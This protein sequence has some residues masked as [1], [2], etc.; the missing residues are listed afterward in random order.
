MANFK[1]NSVTVA[2]ESGGTVS[3]D[4]GVNLT[5][6]A[7]PKFPAGH[8]VQIV[9]KDFGTNYTH[10][11]G[12]SGV[13][14][15]VSGFTTAITPSSS[16]N[17]ILVMLHIGGCSNSNSSEHFGV[18]VK[19]GSTVIGVHDSPGSRSIAMTTHSTPGAGNRVETMS[20]NI[21]DSPNTTS[22]ITYFVEGYSAGE[23]FY[24]NRP[25]SDS[26]SSH[27]LAGTS[28]LILMEVV[29]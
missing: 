24:M 3:L 11:G 26:S 21:L 28:T 8:I 4:S 18:R 25:S 1:L 12:G 29:A 6:L 19:R 22:A 20:G 9:S 13:W 14:S 23:S 16:S 10:S 15:A 2:S 7:G 5:S 17:K 27:Y